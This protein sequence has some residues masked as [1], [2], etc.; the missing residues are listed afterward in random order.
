MLQQADSDLELFGQQ[1]LFERGLPVPFGGEPLTG[2]P[3]PGAPGW[4]LLV[5]H[6]AGQG[7]ENPQPVCRVLPG[8]DEAA[9]FL[10]RIQ[11]LSALARAEQVIAEPGIE[12]WQVG[13]HPPGFGQL[14]GQAGEELMFQVIVQGVRPTVE[15]VAA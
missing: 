15:R 14:R 9:Q 4:P 3:M 1:G 12:T 11:V 2:T 13:Q 8:L 10:Q 6:Q 5:A 7:G